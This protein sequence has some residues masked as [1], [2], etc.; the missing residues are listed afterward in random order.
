MVG[1]HSFISFYELFQLC[2]VG[3]SGHHSFLKFSTLFQLS[4]HSTMAI[5][6]CK[7]VER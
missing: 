6:K 4:P 1:H 3:V 2:T 5:R 7:S